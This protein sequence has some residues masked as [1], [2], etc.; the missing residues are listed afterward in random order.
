MT[1]LSHHFYI[2]VGRHIAT[3]LSC[4]FHITVGR[5]IV[6][7]L[8]C[9]FYI[10]L[11]RPTMIYDDIPMMSFCYLSFK[12]I[13]SSIY[14]LDF[15]TNLGHI[16]LYIIMYTHIYIYIYIYIYICIYMYIYICLYTHIHMYRACRHP[17]SRNLLPSSNQR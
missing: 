10:N 2:T 4:Y 14:T 7:S 17:K 12:K 3:S 15:E 11:G 6:A 16:C 8:S 9:P 13:K 1:S 5:H